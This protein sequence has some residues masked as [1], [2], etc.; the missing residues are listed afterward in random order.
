M[1]GKVARMTKT[2]P[3]G[4]WGEPHF[5]EKGEN[6]EFQQRMKENVFI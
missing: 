4:T 2:M 1:I 6:L 3:Y 5:R